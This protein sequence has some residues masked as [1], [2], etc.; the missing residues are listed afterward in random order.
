MTSPLRREEDNLNHLAIREFVFN[1]PT[2][3]RAYELETLLS[4]AAN[5]MNKRRKPIEDFSINYELG[6]HL[7]KTKNKS[8]N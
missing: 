4:K 5:Y 6:K 8:K 1:N 3:K 2:D 7:E